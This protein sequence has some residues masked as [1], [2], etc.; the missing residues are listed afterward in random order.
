MASRISRKEI[1]TAT[2]NGKKQWN[3]QA[4]RTEIRQLT[5]QANKIL[6]ENEGRTDYQQLAKRLQEASDSKAKRSDAF[7]GNLNFKTSQELEIQLRGLQQFIEYDTLSEQ[8]KQKQ[9]ERFEKA[10]SSYEASTGEE[11]SAAEYEKRVQ[12]FSSISSIIDHYGSGNVRELDKA[13]SDQNKKINLA[14]AFERAEKYATDHGITQTPENILDIVYS[15]N[16]INR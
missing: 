8:A 14:R 1:E 3:V 11:L 15:M 10:K 16:G 4:L 7:V 13:A 2:V 6:M 9:K 12:I 5:K